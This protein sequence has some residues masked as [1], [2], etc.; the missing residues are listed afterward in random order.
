MMSRHGV[1]ASG[2]VARLLA[3]VAAIAAC[4]SALAKP[5]TIAVLPDTQFYCKD[6]PDTFKAQVQWIL[7]N[8][9]AKN[10][11]F[12][13]HLGDITDAGYDRAQW[14]RAE[15]AMRRLDGVLPMGLV[16]GNHDLYL[17]EAEEAPNREFVNRFG[18]QSGYF[19]GK[20]WY[21]GAS[22]SGFS[23]CQKII[24][25]GRALLVVNLDDSAK[26]EELDWARTMLAA[27]RG[28]PAIVVT[29]DYMDATGRRASAYLKE[30][31]RNSGRQIWDK[32]IRSEPQVFMVLCG[33]SH[34][35]RYQ[36]SKNDAGLDVHEMLSDYQMLSRGG[37]GFLRLLTF[38][39]DASRLDVQT[40][41]PTLKRNLNR[42][43]TGGEGRFSIRLAMQSPILAMEGLAAERSKVAVPPVTTQSA[44]ADDERGEPALAG[45]ADEL[46]SV[47][48]MFSLGGRRALTLVCLACAV[49]LLGGTLQRIGRTGR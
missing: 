28:V 23:S 27:Q 4:R 19:K 32:L 21:L 26:D 15:E 47:G 36:V 30:P 7:D 40:W 3:A 9:E 42:F 38:D 33:H 29:H 14:D 31:G 16:A 41:S 39:L 20:P 11:V 8:R 25:E 2:S 35:Q 37:N 10:I 13:A 46:E 43:D 12:V 48:S 49:M 44:D 45:T 22:P 17:N 34:G 24:A 5:F 1:K 18:P 6:H